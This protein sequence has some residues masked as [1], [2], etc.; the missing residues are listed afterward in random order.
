MDINNQRFGDV[1]LQAMRERDA[2]KIKSC[3]NLGIDVNV[4]DGDEPVL[5]KACRSYSKIDILLDH[6]Q[7]NVNIKDRSHGGTALMHACSRGWTYAVD[8]LCK[9]QG[10]EYNMENN[11]G[12]TAAILA[13]NHIQPECVRILSRVP[14]V[15]W[16]IQNLSAGWSPLFFAVSLGH[17]EIVRTILRI[18]TIN[19][20][21]V[22]DKCRT[23]AQ[24]AVESDTNSSLQ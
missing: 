24:L 13:V 11:N 4:Y 16:N 8:R 18:P 15:D 21:L 7:T 3:I 2:Q 17:V 22:D 9:A 10:I 20:S 19:L 6:P 23:I 14:G 5:F 12:E 1:F